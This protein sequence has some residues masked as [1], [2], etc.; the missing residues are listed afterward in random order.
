M[1]VRVQTNH[2]NLHAALKTKLLNFHI[3]T[4]SGKTKKTHEFSNKKTENGK[5]KIQQPSSLTF[6]SQLLKFPNVKTHRC[7]SRAVSQIALLSFLVSSFEAVN[8]G[9]V[10]SI[11]H[12]SESGI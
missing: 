7:W 8:V 3:H 1:N 10:V 11:L 6:P 12:S 9:P 4:L 5:L 2:L